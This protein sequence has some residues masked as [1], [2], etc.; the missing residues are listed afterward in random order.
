MR[1][2]LFL[3]AGLL[4]LTA[5]FIVG[6]L[7]SANYPEALR[8]VTIAFVALWAAI[9]GFN[10]WVGVN[11]AGYG[12]MEELPIFLMLFGVPAIVAILLKW[13]AF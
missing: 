2:A 6:K 9:T 13:K 11:R 12:A 5:F 4:L 3:I 8:V 7:F 1:T 10:M